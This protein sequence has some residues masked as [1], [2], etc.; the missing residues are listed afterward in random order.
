MPLLFIDSTYKFVGKDCAAAYIVV[1]S[2]PQSID[3]NPFALLF[4]PGAMVGRA[5]ASSKI[6]MPVEEGDA[7]NQAVLTAGVWQCR[8][9]LKSKSIE[10]TQERVAAPKARS[11]C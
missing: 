8:G 9:S 11:G 7:A 1:A 4:H 5:V 2:L 10:R 3:A 6:V